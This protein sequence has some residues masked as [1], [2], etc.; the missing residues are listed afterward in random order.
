M[1]TR[2][3]IFFTS[4]WH[5]GHKNVI[6]FDKRPFKDIDHMHK[7][8]INN[9]NSSVREND[10]C[11]F[12]GDIGLTKNSVV[13]KV[14]KELNGTKVVILGNH[15]R[16]TFSMYDQGFDVVLNA[17]VFYIGDHRV[18]MSHCPLPGIFREDVKGMKGAKEGENWHGESKNQRFTSQDLTVDFHLHGHCHSGPN[19]TKEVSTIKQYDVGVPGNNYRP[20]SISQIE[21][22]IAKSID[23]S[24]KI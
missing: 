9:Y 3:N 17:G 13:S 18:S 21:S 8:L 15:D 20:V 6:T 2:K 7:V 22:W 5:I 24:K 4:D 12:L 11:Y 1:S 16:N 10:I 23:I 14:I 19:N